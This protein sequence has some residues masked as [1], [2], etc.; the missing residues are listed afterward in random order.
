MVGE[1]REA[2]GVDGLD[3]V[4]GG[5]L[6]ERQ[7]ALVRGPP[8]VGKTVFGLHFLDG[9]ADDEESLYINFG[10]P[11]EYVRRTA[12]RFGIDPESLEFLE[13]APTA[14]RFAEEEMYTLFSSGDVEQPSLINEVRETV[15]SLQPDRVLIDPITE[16][17]FLTADEHQFRSQI[18]GLT[19]FLR[20][21]GATVLMTSQVADDLSDTDLR[22]M[23]DVII[24]LDRTTDAWT[25][26]VTKFRGPPVK[27]GP[28]G[29]EITEAGV[30]VWPRL[31]PTQEPVDFPAETI[32]AGVPELDQLL[33]GGLQR[34]TV[35]FFSGPTG[36]GKTTTSLQFVK[37]AASRGNQSLILSCEE[38]VRT[39]LQRS[40]ALNIGL[41]NMIDQGRVDIVELR[42]EEYTAD[43]ITNTVQSAVEDDGVEIVLV[44]GFQGFKRNLRGFGDK[45]PVDYLTAIGRYLREQGV[46]TL[47]TNEVHQITGEFRVTEEEMSNL[48]DNIV[49]LRHLEYQGSIDK[50]I[51]VLK[52]RTSDFEDT[53]RRIEFTE[54]GISVGEPLTGLSGI[55][56]GTPTFDEPRSEHDTDSVR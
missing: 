16:F 43:Q 24:D 4:L 36:A 27:R 38:S 21:E 19:D 7:N 12:D 44:D 34:G 26:D 6:L 51:G 9:A 45:D 33:D 42:P 47:V 52:M 29:Y 49:F 32:S 2:T 28:H 55:L 20:G 48:A 50:V 18:M 11:T 56:T 46:T 54:Y 17:R 53:L 3:T 39:M 41:E 30:E 31:V 8:G 5:G 40:E 35:T 1:A 14:D 23:T 22:F 15:E 37:E 13:L 10:E 25:V